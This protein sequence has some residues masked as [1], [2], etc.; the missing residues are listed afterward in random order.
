MD[1]QTKDTELGGTSVVQFDGTLLDLGFF[2]EGVPSEVDVSV[3][4]VT[5]EFVTG[6]WDGLHE[7]T[8]Q[9]SNEGDDLYNSGGWDG[10]WSE[11]GG[12]T[13]GV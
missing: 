7:R 1:H 4:E 8:F 3:T 9:Y 13:V 5:N 11:D 12:N 6:V 10:I 2:I